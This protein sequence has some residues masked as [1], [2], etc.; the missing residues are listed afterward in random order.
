[1]NEK[2][3]R[4]CFISYSFRYQ[5]TV[6]HLS[7]I[8]DGLGVET[9]RADLVTS[10]ATPLS[11]ISKAIEEA[12]FFVLVTGRTLSKS[13]TAFEFGL[14]LGMSKPV[15]VIAMDRRPEFDFATNVHLIKVKHKDLSSVRQDID[16]FI[17]RMVTSE[18]TLPTREISNE[19]TWVKRELKNLREDQGGK[20]ERHLTE[21]VAR[22]FET[23]K[24]EV[25]RESR[26]K[27]GNQ[28]DL[29][30]W[31]DDLVAALGGPLAVECRYYRGG[32]GSVK[33]NARHALKKL[34]AF[35]ETSTASL[36]LLVF[37]HDRPTTLSI[38]EYDTP[39]VLT[40]SVDD[41][42]D[43]CISN[44]LTKEVIQRR[45]HAAHRP[46]KLL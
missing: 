27:K 25:L 7:L 14:A 15:L 39:K 21:F 36:G 37:I 33:S 32:T 10:S 9:V 45:N 26:D 28:S 24:A 43:S 4:S 2:L 18:Q 44:S 16:R 30:I 17:R 42:I 38:K 1:M 31:S 5:E 22:L 41:L 11:E 6:N 46:T 20:S 12:D 34:T 19:Y 23:Q 8:L 13:N 3:S 40:F 35:V 29:Y